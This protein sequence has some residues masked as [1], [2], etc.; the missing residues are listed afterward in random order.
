MGVGR[1]GKVGGGHSHNINV[2]SG[3][4]LRKILFLICSCLQEFGRS[5]VSS[6]SE[7]F[8]RVIPVRLLCQ[9]HPALMAE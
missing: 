9:F 7:V 6:E 2:Y 1:G 5:S 8:L 3:G 4:D